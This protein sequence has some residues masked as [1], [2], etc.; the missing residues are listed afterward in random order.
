MT[1][2]LLTKVAYHLAEDPPES[3]TQYCHH[4]RGVKIVSNSDGLNKLNWYDC[5]VRQARL[6]TAEAEIESAK[7]RNNL[8]EI[9]ALAKK[10]AATYQA[11]QQAIG[12]TDVWFE[13]PPIMPP[14]NRWVAEWTKAMLLEMYDRNVKSVGFGWQTGY[15]Q[16]RPFDS[17]QSPDEW[18]VMY[19]ALE[20]MHQIGTGWT[21]LGVE[22]Y[23]LNAT[24]DPSKP[25]NGLFNP[26]DRSSVCRLDFVYQYHI[27]P[28]GWDIISTV[29]ESG[30]DVPG[31]WLIKGMGPENAMIGIRELDRAYAKRPYVDAFFLYTVVDPV[32]STEKDY[33]YTPPYLEVI[34]QWV[35]ANPPGG[36]LTG[37]TPPPDNPP[38]PPPPDP[39]P[40]PVNLIRNSSFE[41][42]HT[43]D[44]GD[45]YG[46]RKI[47]DGWAVK[48]NPKQGA[49]HVELDQDPP[50]VKT[51]ATSLR[52]WN[53]T[54][55]QAWYYQTL[56]LEAG[57]TYQAEVWAYGHRAPGYVGN[58][59]TALAI[60]VAGGTEYSEAAL[61]DVQSPVDS[62]MKLSITFVAE[63]RTTLFLQART[64]NDGRGDAW[65]DS[66]SITKTVAAP[67][68]QVT[69]R[70]AI[71]TDDNLHVRKGP[72]LTYEIVYQ[73][74]A[75][76]VVWVE[77]ITGGWAKLK[78]RTK[79][80][81]VYVSEEY[82]HLI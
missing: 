43:F 57:A 2:E 81:E 40:V 36:P 65:F 27:W 9:P 31:M 58:V 70:K 37:S 42:T 10:T 41:G 82:L 61:V 63:G 26:D 45:R 5:P 73:L 13:I 60:D 64:G 17:V 16:V 6:I 23:I 18:E 69:Y 28:N 32:R 34:E 1:Q 50:H 55:F 22:E 72:G 30:F 4:G 53:D 20:T 71:V 8:S 47:A 66:V 11:V 7:S 14:A 24:I 62:W 80:P 25:N 21:R 12:L 48:W 59:R 74:M 52:I 75:E 38:T 33:A 3:F 56:D 44:P 15:P 67:P 78:P 51:D 29:I 76:E 77:K 79:Y 49:P 39:A 46:D 35:L 19:P 68:Q 54:R